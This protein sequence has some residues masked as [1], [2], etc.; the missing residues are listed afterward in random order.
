MTCLPPPRPS[1]LWQPRDYTVWDAN[2]DRIYEY[3]LVNKNDR[4]QT[5]RIMEERHGFPEFPLATWEHVLRVHFKFRKNLDR[6]DWAPIGQHLAKRRKLGKTTYAIDLCGIQLP[7]RRVEKNVPKPLTLDASGVAVLKEMLPD[8]ILQTRMKSPFNQTMLR[9]PLYPEIVDLRFL[10]GI[11]SL[12]TPTLLQ[13]WSNI[14]FDARYL[15]VEAFKRLIEFGLKVKDR[16]WARLF[17]QICWSSYV[18]NEF[19]HH[20]DAYL[21][22]IIEIECSMNNTMFSSF[23]TYTLWYTA[24][25]RYDVDMMKILIKLGCCVSQISVLEQQEVLRTII[26]STSFESDQAGPAETNKQSVLCG[27][28]ER[29]SQ[30]VICL[31]YLL[32][33]GVMVGPPLPEDE[34]YWNGPG[35]PTLARDSLWMASLRHMTDTTTSALLE[36]FHRGVD[37][38]LTFSGICRAAIGGLTS[39]KCYLE[40]IPRCNVTFRSA[41]LEV[42][43]SEAAAQG[44]YDIIDCLLEYG[45]DPNVPSIPTHF[46][47]GDGLNQVFNTWNPISRAI[48]NQDLET[49]KR[50]AYRKGSL[51][52]HDVLFAVLFQDGDFWKPTLDSLISMGLN[53]YRFGDDEV[54]QTAF[55]GSVWAVYNKDLKSRWTSRLMEIFRLY[56]I[57]FD[58]KIDGLD[59]LHTAIR[60]SCNV[61]V[62]KTLLNLGLIVHSIPCEEDG[63]TMLHDALRSHSDD[64]EDIVE[65]LLYNGADP[66][67]GNGEL[68]LEAPFSDALLRCRITQDKKRAEENLRLYHL[69]ISRGAMW[70][71][72]KGNCGTNLITL[73][74]RAEADDQVI[75]EALDRGYSLDLQG[76]HD[77]VTPLME[78]V[79]A[80]RWD[81]ACNFLHRGIDINASTGDVQEPCVDQ[82]IGNG[83][84]ALH[85]AC[86]YSAPI[87]FLQ[88]L[89]DLGANVDAGLELATETPLFYA[90]AAG[91]PIIVSLLI[92]HGAGINAIVRLP[93]LRFLI[94]PSTLLEG[95]WSP[96]DYASFRGNLEVVQLLFDLGGRSAIRTFTEVDGA[97]QLARYRCE[98]GVLR[99]FEERIGSLC[100]IPDIEG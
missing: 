96:L 89:F 61:E 26:F 19:D 80:R 62:V 63:S 69:M 17:L 9:L 68:L 43:L 87:S 34:T 7:Q 13:F 35:Q 91:H 72:N 83:L 25:R 56:G 23:F 2:R 82:P 90:I 73:L 1:L 4:V 67:L 76:C 94:L 66:T 71:P 93:N 64:R 49:V 53:P 32:D 12:N 10:H 65:L 98:L 78:S 11:F 54:V 85:L 95:E 38:I 3:Y 5:K 40:G 74:I 48:L 42:S 77:P 97:V 37:E 99:F 58:K 6:E 14:L 57:P 22:R 8:W 60:Q 55:S 28:R 36:H 29:G 45:I 46:S 70:S 18:N 79:Q 88:T 31:T 44:C 41:I 24:S 100:R 27:S 16:E 51:Q 59:F 52:V 92:A 81:L 84:T 20:F 47:V 75:F 30:S 21:R 50:L 39:L 33:N 86:D 15:N